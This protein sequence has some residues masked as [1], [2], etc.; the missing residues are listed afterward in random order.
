MSNNYRCYCVMQ[1]KYRRLVVV[2]TPLRPEERERK[3]LSGF[4]HF[5]PSTSVAVRSGGCNRTHA[6]TAA[7]RDRFSKESGQLSPA[8]G[9]KNNKKKK[10]NDEK[11]GN[12]NSSPRYRSRSPDP[13]SLD[14]TWNNSYPKA[15]RERSN[16]SQWQ[17]QQQNQPKQKHSAGG[18]PASSASGS[19]VMVNGHLN[20]AH[21]DQFEQE[22]IQ[23]HQQQSK[24]SDQQPLRFARCVKVCKQFFFSSRNLGPLPYRR[25]VN[26]GLSI[27][28]LRVINGAFFCYFSEGSK[29]DLAVARLGSSCRHLS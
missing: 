18:Y 8:T 27:P 5:S 21:Y 14:Q 11:M 4:P 9:Q 3:D 24:L 10:G 6:E 2:P 29:R 20:S 23:H 1:E 22:C 15:E 13:S 26:S 28:M 19:G 25:I 7:T 16:R 12:T 17:Q